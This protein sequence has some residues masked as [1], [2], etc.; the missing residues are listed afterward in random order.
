[1]Q[2]GQRGPRYPTQIGDLPGGGLS[3]SR[4]RRCLSFWDLFVPRRGLS[5]RDDGVGEIGVEGRCYLPAMFLQTSPP[6]P[7]ATFNRKGTKKR[8]LREK[9]AG[10]RPLGPGAFPGVPGR[11]SHRASQRGRGLSRTQTV[12]PASAREGRQ[13]GRQA[14]GRA[15]L[16]Q[17]EQLCFS[18]LRLTH[19]SLESRLSRAQP[20]K[21]GLF[22]P[23]RP[24][25]NR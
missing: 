3:L 9:T 15:C 11:V 4:R 2:L 13:A 20:C 19:R 8:G 10:L 18:P 14:G 23:D 22:R 6:V 25:R 24:S 12:A 5:Q 1:M 21:S 16:R 17:A 7:G